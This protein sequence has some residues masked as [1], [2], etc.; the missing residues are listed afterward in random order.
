M[1]LS[2]KIYIWFIIVSLLMVVFM[3]LV[4]ECGHILFCLLSGGKIFE[5]GYAESS[6]GGLFYVSTKYPNQTARVIGALGGSLF[7]C[8]IAFIICKII[9]K[10]RRGVVLFFGCALSFVSACVYWSISPLIE[11][12]D[13]YN[14][15]MATNTDFML[16][17]TL[18]FVWTGI[19]CFL[20]YFYWLRL[21][22][23][24]DFF[25]K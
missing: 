4:H 24:T 17:S 9:W 5:V 23:E 12:G 6:F 8:V 14:F 19:T 11:F 21:M 16:M 25:G 1:R 13:G 3:C 20:V 15:A 2:K 10:T 22:D 18:G 7:E